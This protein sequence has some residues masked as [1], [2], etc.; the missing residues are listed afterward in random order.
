M[1]NFYRQLCDSIS[2]NKRKGKN[3]IQKWKQKF[4]YL[5]VI[6][7]KERRKSWGLEARLDTVRDGL[8]LKMN[9]EKFKYLSVWPRLTTRTPSK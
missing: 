6:D 9:D 5:I 7:S 8:P 2:I 3:V 1:S 4:Q